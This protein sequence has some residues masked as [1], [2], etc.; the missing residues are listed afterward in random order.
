MVPNKKSVPIIII[1]VA[2]GLLVAYYFYFLRKPH[3][4]GAVGTA[5]SASESI[6]NIT[7]NPANKV[8]EVNPL[9][10]A[11]PFKYNNPLR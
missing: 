10:R 1:L 4:G 2:T 3:G 5:K 7:T 11:N 9:D 6:P 8:P